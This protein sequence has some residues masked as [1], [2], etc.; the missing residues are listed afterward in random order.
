MINKIKRKCAYL[1]MMLAI[2]ACLNAQSIHMPA[3]AVKMNWRSEVP[4]PVYPDSSLV[5]LYYKTWELAS[6]R[7]RKGPVGLPASP[8]LDENC[9]EDQIW[10]WDTCLMTMFSK[11]CPGR[12]PGKESLMNLYTPIHDRVYTPLKIHL[13]DNPP[14]FAWVE[15]EY[16]KFTGDL[17][18]AS[19]VMRQKRYLQ[20]HFDYFN[21]VPT[22]NVDTLVS[23]SYQPIHRKVYG[24]KD[25]NGNLHVSGYSWHGGASGMD[26]TPRGRDAGGYQSV[27]WIDAISQQALSAD[28]MSK[29]AREL[30]MRKEAKY[31]KSQYEELRDTINKLYWDEQDGMYYDISVKDHKPCRIKTPASYWAMLAGIPSTSRA[32][33]MLKYIRNEDYMGGLYP[34]NSLSRD[35]KDYDSETGEYWRGG[36]WLP[37][38]YMGTKALERYGF[39][40]LADSLATRVVYQMLRTYENYTPHTI[41]ETYSPS[42][43][44]PSTEYGK[45]VRQDFCGWSALGPI[46]LFIENIMGFRSVNALDNIVVWDIK[47]VNG[48][49]GL[50]S[51]RFGRVAC[52]LIFNPQTQTIETSSN[53]P[54]TLMA[55][56][57]RIKVRRG[58][59]AYKLRHAP[60]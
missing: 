12:F 26:N 58:E 8:Y 59:H 31:W 17:P 48:R 18:H 32:E 11:Y 23:P 2:P 40:N 37:M 60:Q 53:A 9:Y 13:R 6:G 19:L 15:S 21:T 36:V 7:V 22:G 47:A 25:K 29:L 50:K 49:H 27:L 10:I 56:G 41:W 45:R 54:F 28:C 51:L 42:G 43:D 14:I 24:R 3:D 38:A 52:S 30:G 44:F 35:D 55:N 16:Y 5:K 39:Y 1:G 4:A 20:K 34:W 33:R 46:S 57:Q